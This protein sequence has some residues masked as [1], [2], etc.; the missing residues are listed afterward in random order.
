MKLNEPPLHPWVA[1]N[2]DGSVQVAHCNCM[3]GM[4]EACSHVSATLFHLLAQAEM[5]R[6]V[7]VTSQKC[8]WSGV[9]SITKIEPKRGKDIQFTKSKRLKPVMLPDIP[10]FS[11]DEEQ[12]FYHELSET[13]KFES[14]PVK[15]AILS[16][17][18]GYADSYVPRIC[19][20]NIP[21]PLTDLF[22]VSN[23]KLT[24]E[25]LLAKSDNVFANIK[26]TKSQSDL[27]EF[28]TR[29]QTNCRLWYQ[30]RAG[31]ITA[32]SVKAVLSTS[33]HNP[34]KS[35]VNKICDPESAKFSSDATNWGCNQEKNARKLYEINMRT[36]HDDFI[37]TD[38]GFRISPQY[39]FIGASPDACVS[40]SCCGE[41]ICEIKCPFTAKSKTITEAATYSKFCLTSDANGDLQLS[42][43]HAYYYQVQTQL[44]A[45]ES[46]Y[47]DFIVFTANDND[48]D[49][50]VERIYMDHDFILNVVSE[51]QTFYV[52]VILPNLLAK[53]ITCRIKR[54]ENTDKEKVCYCQEPPTESML[55]CVSVSCPIKMFH[56]D[57]LKIMKIPKRWYCPGCRTKLNKEKR[58]SQK[59]VSTSPSTDQ[60]N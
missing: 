52:S 16:I 39:P 53:V 58:M 44:L 26:I 43:Q 25:E 31:R 55:T 36:S 59:M 33:V 7:S 3:A 19:N 45:T 11:P 28:E 49:L 54:V 46:N 24:H 5:K 50:F 6:S 10:T 56:A 21:K 14:K 22:D 57:C 2:R 27:V 20:S 35:V 9:Q 13:C 29:K 34:S 23:R 8:K 48:N 41:G 1:V 51:L 30:Q 12:M 32:S 60:V 42:R 38:A 4:G 15:A 37:I 47:C 17:I 18:P 40:C